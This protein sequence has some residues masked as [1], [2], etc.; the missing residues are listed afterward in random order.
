MP[1]YLPCNFR[2]PYSA[3]LLWGFVVDCVSIVASNL[4]NEKKWNKLESGDV[5]V[6]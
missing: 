5:G 2:A 4:T 3:T 1:E 6:G